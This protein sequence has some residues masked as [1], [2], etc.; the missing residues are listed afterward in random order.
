MGY[1]LEQFANTVH[2]ILKEDPGPKGREKVCAVVQE[3]LVDEAFLAKHL[4]DDVPERKILY[5]D[6]EL[7]FCILAHSY[8]GAKES[9]PHDHGPSWA[10]SGKVRRAREYPLKPGMAKVYNVG[11]VH[12]P[13]REGATRLIRV[14]GTNMDKVKRLS[15]EKV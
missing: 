9:Q 12:S 5:E 2:G 10:I 6:P 15:F 7:G 11:D 4:G 8:N 13:R 3:V 1:S 14:E